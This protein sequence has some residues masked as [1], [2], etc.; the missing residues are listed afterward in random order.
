MHSAWHDANKVR[1]LS[2]TYGLKDTY[3]QL[4]LHPSERRKAI[5]ILRD[6]SARRVR[7]FV[8]NTLPFGSTAS[9][10]QFNHIS[11]LLQR[12]LCEL[13]LVSA[14]YYD[15]FPP[16]MPAMLGQGSDRVT[17]AVMQLLSFDMSVDKESPYAS[18]SEMLG[19]VLDTSDEAMGAVHLWNRPERS[20]AMSKSP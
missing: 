9:V 2:R 13:C 6:P 7:A 18:L 8:C 20:E 19:I 15:D 4:P 5:I 10:L 14:C 11:L 1:P 3:K 17:H 16:V 12:I